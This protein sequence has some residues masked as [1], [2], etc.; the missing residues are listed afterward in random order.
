MFTQGVGIDPEAQSKSYLAI[1]SI[2]APPGRLAEDDM[3]FFL[4][5]N[6]AKLISLVPQ[7]SKLLFEK[8]LK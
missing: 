3:V 5:K 1:S 7:F 8:I 6:G 2:L 4:M